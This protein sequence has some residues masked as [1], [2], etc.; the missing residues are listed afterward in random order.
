MRQLIFVFF[1]SISLNTLAQLHDNNPFF[2]EW[3]VMELMPAGRFDAI[4]DLGNGILITGSRNPYPGKIFLS[5]DYGKNWKLTQE[6]GDDK[7]NGGITCLAK[8]VDNIAYLLTQQGE[9]WKSVDRGVNW[10]K[11]MQITSNKNKDGFAAAYSILV[12]K[13]GTVLVSNTDSDGG[14]IFRSVDNGESFTDLGKISD[15]GLY[16]FTDVGKGVMINGWEGK[17]FI[18]Y[19]DGKSWQVSGSLEGDR[20]IYATEYLGASKAIQASEDGNIYKGDIWSNKWEKVATL[21]GAADDFAYLGYGV[22]IYSTYTQ[23][24][25]IY[26]SADYGSNWINIGG[27]GTKAFGDW[28]DHFI[29][30]QTDDKVICIGGTNKGFILRAEISRDKLYEY[31]LKA[32]KQKA[33]SETIGKKLF[34]DALVGSLTDYESLNEPEDVLIKGDYAYVPSRDGNNVAIIDIRQ[35]KSPTVVANFRDSSLVDAMGVAVDN[36]ILYVVSTINHKLLIVDIKD[37][38]NPKKLSELTI[39]GNGATADRLRKVFYQDGYVYVTHS[40]EGKLYIC[41][42]RNSRKP[43]VIGSVATGDGAFAVI[44]HKNIAYVGGCFPGASLKVVDVKN[45]KNPRLI[46]TLKDD[47]RFGCICSFEIRDNKLYTVAYSSN[48]FIVFDIS[49]PQQPVE[50]GYC[51]S[52]MLDGPGR[53]KLLGNSAYVINSVNNTL[54]KVDI[55]IPSAPRVSYLLTDRLLEKAYGL[56]AKDGYLYVA[57]RESRTLSVIK[58]ELISTAE[59]GIIGFLQD[60]ININAPEDIVVRNKIAYIPCRDGSTL[61]LVD[62]HDPKNPTILNVYQDEELDVAMG[63]DIYDNYLY[64]VSMANRKVLILDISDPKAIKKISSIQLGRD[65]G[66]FNQLRKVLYR[67]GHLFITQGNIG[68]LFIVDIRDPKQP[69]KISEVST[70]D[71]AFNMYFKDNYVYSGGC[72]GT[73]L[74]VIDIKD[75]YNPVLVNTIRDVNTYNCFCSYGSVGKYF[76]GIGYFSKTFVVLDISNPLDIKEV[77]VINDDR[78]NGANR[79]VKHGNFVYIATALTDGMVKIDITDPTRPEIVD[80]MT[81][82]L[83]DKAYGVTYDE[84][85]IY[86][87]GR[88]ADSIVILD[89]AVFK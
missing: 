26:L 76:F 39:G 21:N 82:Q 27:T 20:P 70:G 60:S 3:E 51:R 31:S 16:R 18:S 7:G 78:I 23:K 55:S 4:A 84:G 34:A 44:V 89:D 37:R 73:S 28:L 43:V 30:V 32:N 74:N 29:A 68:K 86:L 13:L 10:K 8:G 71:G 15:K 42:V 22:V 12:T 75:L 72:V 25:D 69:R 47:K 2:K 5:T 65:G 79:L 14:H 81:S 85:L 17:V 66:D 80:M 62:V 88:D 38:A 45:K 87:V 77:A 35:P 57:G 54:A 58:E 40:S 11:I 41:D 33:Y 1:L 46:N 67:E 61:T 56:D 53:L 9:F 59:K 49:Q 36:D 83:L 19:N 52:E 24:R 63:L 50:I 64:L 6:I 48:A